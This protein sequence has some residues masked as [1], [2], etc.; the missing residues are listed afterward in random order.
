M[1]LHNH[2][3]APGTFE[4]PDHK[5]QRPEYPVDDHCH[6]YAEH[7][8]SHVFTQ[9]VTECD[10]EDP[11]GQYGYVHACLGISRRTEGSRQ[12]K[13]YGPDQDCADSMEMDDLLGCLAVTSDRL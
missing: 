1:I 13:G 2:A 9:H 7:A 10:S 11:H 8:Q 3:F 4:I 12:R 6:P 5:A